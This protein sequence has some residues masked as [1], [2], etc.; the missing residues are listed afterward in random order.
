MNDGCNYYEVLNCIPTS[1]FE[2]LKRNYKS[3]V[4]QYHPDK[5]FTAPSEVYMQIDKAWKTLSDPE[6]RSRYDEHLRQQAAYSSYVIY[7]TLSM[8]DMTCDPELKRYTYSCRCGGS[9]TIDECE[10]QFGDTI[11]PCEDCSLAIVIKTLLLPSE[12]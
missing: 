11:V 2:E 3:L 6:L 12:R 7:D 1:S 4:L 10:L 9:Y 8:D 5:C